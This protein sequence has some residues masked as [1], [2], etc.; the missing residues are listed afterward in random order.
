MIGSI[1]APD[2]IGVMRVLRLPLLRIYLGS[3]IVR[4]QNHRNVEYNIV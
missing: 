4:T 1:R 2:V 3:H